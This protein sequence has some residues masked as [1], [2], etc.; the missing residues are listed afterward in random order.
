MRVAGPLSQKAIADKT[1]I[2]QGKLSRWKRGQEQ[3][4]APFVVQFARGMGRP[5]IEA[6][7]AAGFLTPDEAALDPTSTAP[8]APLTTDTLLT[9]LEQRVEQSLTYAPLD[10]LPTSDLLAE[11]SRRTEATR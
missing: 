1:G 2:D 7:V 4:T 11:I 6:L 10:Q 8:T 5:P 3:Q 9:L